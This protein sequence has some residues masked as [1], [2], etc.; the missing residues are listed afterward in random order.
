MKR[1]FALSSVAHIAFIALIVI[2]GYRKTFYLSS[3]VIS[4]KLVSEEH[5]APKQ[6]VKAPPPKEEKV[7]PKKEEP[8]AKIAYEPEKKTRK[9]ETEKAPPSKAKT[10]PKKTEPA[11]PTPAKTSATGGS[12]SKVR[13]DD[14]DFRFA[15]YLEIVKERI[16]SNWSPPPVAGAAE[17]VVSTVYFKISRDGHLMDVKI[18]KT[19]EFDLFDRSALRAVDRSSPLPPLPAGF[20]GSWLGVHFEF[21][22]KSG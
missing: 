15:Y 22:Q 4:V 8:K 11:R 18:E 3:E 9:T 12:E 10:E 16:S 6:V 5:P 7:E 19:S 17:G 2:P 20:K 14:K 13:V 21:E 1:S